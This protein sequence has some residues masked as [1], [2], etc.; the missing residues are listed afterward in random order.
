MVSCQQSK[1]ERTMRLAVHFVI[2][3]VVLRFEEVSSQSD[4]TLKCEKF[5]DGV[6]V[7]TLCRVN[8]AGVNAK[9]AVTLITLELLTSPVLRQLATSEYPACN[10]NWVGNGRCTSKDSVT[11][12]YTYQMKFTADNATMHGL[13]LR[14]WSNCLPSTPGG[15]IPLTAEYSTCDPIPIVVRVPEEAAA[16]GTGALIGI[17]IASTVVGAAILVGIVFWIYKCIKS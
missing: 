6:E 17:I 1:W 9:C 14:C 3:C 4:F 10:Q 2:T 5:P 13:A 12:V 15:S 11:N 16:L 8:G 7:T